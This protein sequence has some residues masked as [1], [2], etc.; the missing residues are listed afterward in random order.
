MLAIAHGER[1]MEIAN[2][3][4]I[5]KSIGETALSFSRPRS[6]ETATSSTEPPTQDKVSLMVNDVAVK[7]KERDLQI[8]A[9][10]IQKA[11]RAMNF[12]LKFQ[13]D[14]ETDQVIMKVV[15]EEGEVIREIP[16]EEQIRLA[17][18]LPDISD[19]LL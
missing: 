14:A 8:L 15:N 1:E 5:I 12:S 18:N 16:P 2:I 6:P 11:V 13:V 4:N 19:L 10:N 9:S 17:R 3:S 7:N